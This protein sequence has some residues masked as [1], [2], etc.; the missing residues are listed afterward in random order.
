MKHWMGIVL[1][2]W[3][4]QSQASTQCGALVQELEGLRSAQQ[5]IL[6]SLAA[7]HE[8]FA[9]SYEEVKMELELH[10]KNINKKA[11]KAMGRT[12]EAFRSRGLKA[13]Q[14]AEKLDLLTSKLIS[15]IS[16][17]LKK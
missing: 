6:N 17:C 14:Q 8:T 11:L 1:F 9:T 13:N 2:A 10:S 12:A 4:L 15:E 5:S 16:I 3:G 7:N